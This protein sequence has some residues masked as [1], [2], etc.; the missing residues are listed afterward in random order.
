[1]AANELEEILGEFMNTWGNYFEP[2]EKTAKD[3]MRHDLLSLIESEKVKAR[4]DECEK[5]IELLSPGY[6][7]EF[8]FK[9]IPDRIKE[10]E[11]KEEA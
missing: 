10:L 2:Y 3:N 11:S 8:W 1:M 5:I 4:I 6:D 9:I 7:Y